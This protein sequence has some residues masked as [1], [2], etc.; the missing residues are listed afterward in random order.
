[1]FT[2]HF[3]VYIWKRSENL[4]TQYRSAS[5]D[6]RSIHTQHGSGCAFRFNLTRSYSSE[7]WHIFSTWLDLHYRCEITFAQSAHVVPISHLPWSTNARLEPRARRRKKIT[8][9]TFLAADDGGLTEVSKWWP[10]RFSPRQQ[11]VSIRFGLLRSLSMATALYY[12]MA[13]HKDLAFSRSDVGSQQQISQNE[14]NWT[15]SDREC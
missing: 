2:T 5:R 7:G 1:M 6:N 11:V 8:K 12:K 9:C 4:N 14:V 3:Y 10:T 15:V 13:G